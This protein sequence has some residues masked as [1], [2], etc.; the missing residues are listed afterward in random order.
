[1]VSQSSG[2]KI[3][4]RVLPI[5][6]LSFDA[7]LHHHRADADDL[8]ADEISGTTTAVD[9]YKSVASLGP[10]EENPTLVDTMGL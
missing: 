10:Q 6:T 2:K 8:V 4:L 9:D 5:H 7:L 3:G 1:M